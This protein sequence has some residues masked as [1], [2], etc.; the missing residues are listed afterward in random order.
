MDTIELLERDK[1][2]V[3]QRLAGAQDSQQCISV[4]EEELGRILCVYNEECRNDLTAQVAGST[5]QTAKAAL[6]FIDSLGEVKIYE[7]TLS[8]SF[9]VGKPD[10]EFLIRILTGGLMILA[11][12]LLASSGRL[13]SLIFMPVCLILAAA[14]GFCLFLTGRDSGKGA[15]RRTEQIIQKEYDPGKLYHHLSTVLTVVDQELKEASEA[16]LTTGLAAK[17]E[18]QTD[19]LPLPEEE[20]KLLEGILQAAY[21]QK[22]Q[23]YSREVISDVKY[24]LYRRAIEV[25]DYSREADRYFDRLPS[26]N[27]GTIRP[28]LIQEGTLLCKGLAAAGDET[29][30]QDFCQGN[31]TAQEK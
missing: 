16:Q 19:A 12:V 31:F 5:I 23:P 21:L 13:S 3:L 14:G 26:G 4:L 11:A 7:R 10:R 20:L 22:D 27:T 30:V 2:K 24:Y 28:A 9:G 29:D 18:L 1:E 25:I 8:D 17:I 6:P 15:K